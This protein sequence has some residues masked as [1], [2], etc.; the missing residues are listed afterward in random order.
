M[1]ACAFIALLVTGSVVGNDWSDRDM[2]CPPWFR[3][4][5]TST[6]TQMYSHC[7]CSPYLPFRM[8]CDQ[9]TYTSYLKLGNCAFQNNATGNT[10]VGDCPY[11]FPDHL[12]EDQL[13]QLPQNIDELNSMICK[14][15][16][17]EVG[18][19]M[20]GRC[21]NGT[22]PSVS[23]IGSQCVECNALNILNYILLQYL[24]ATIIFL[25]ILLAQIDITSAP[26]AHYILFCNAIV[27]RQGF[28]I[29]TKTSYKYLLR[30]FLSLNSILSFDPLYYVSPPL[31]LSTHIQ[32]IDIPYIEMLA[33]LYPFFILVL[34]FI[35]IELH[36]R[37]FKPVVVLFRPLH[38]K[39][40]RFRRS[41]NPR[42]SLVQSFA[43]IFFI[44]FTKLLF[45]IFIPFNHTDF[46]N[47]NGTVVKGLKVTYIDPTVSFGHGKHIYLMVSFASILIFIILPPIIVLIAYPTRLFRRLQERFSSRVNLAIGTFVNTFQGCYKDGLNGTRDY[48]AMS[49]GILAFIVVMGILWSSADMLV[50]V[51]DRQPIIFQQLTILSLIAVTVMMATLRPYKSETANHTAVCLT[52][53]LAAVGTLCILLDTST[54]EISYYVIVF[55]GIPLLSIPH[56]IFYIYVLYQIRRKVNFKTIV[57]VCTKCFKSEGRML[58]DQALLT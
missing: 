55:I 24:P 36:A 28:F 51:N 6:C 57:G 25:L 58:E 31:C 20:C 52:A 8:M 4:I 2:P 40:I 46:M 17:R 14:N 54:N 41:W 33:T 15:L 12:F 27:I 42:A 50:E 53:L 45:L 26:M 30:A 10:I 9:Y 56:C 43:T 3:A 16:T 29:F 37:D 5:N 32:D 34:A 35:L 38:Q 11:V 18:Q 23:S 7:F 49:G 48:R 47:Q 21:V 22:G 19:S 44:S 39:L 13:L 1:Y